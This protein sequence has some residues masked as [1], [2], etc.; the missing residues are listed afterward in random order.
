MTRLIDADALSEKLCKITTFIKD[1]DDEIGDGFSDD[2]VGYIAEL[3]NAK[4][5]EP[6]GDYVTVET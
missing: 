6:I 3:F 4:R 5:A 2:I 1:G